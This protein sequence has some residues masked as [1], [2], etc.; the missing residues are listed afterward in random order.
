MKYCH[1]CKTMKSRDEFTKRTTAFDGLEPQC[2]PCRGVYRKAYYAKTREKSIAYSRSW[3]RAN[4]DKQRAYGLA[5]RLKQYGLSQEDY[6]ALRSRNDGACDICGDEGDR[7]DHCHATGVVRGWLCHNCN[8]TL[9]HSGDR[10][11][12]L[13]QAADYLDRFATAVDEAAS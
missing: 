10:S 12:R 5:S 1:T 3:V 13:R 9:G 8:V 7:I 2:K 4:R 6:E 11:D